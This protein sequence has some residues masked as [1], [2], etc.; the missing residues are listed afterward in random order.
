MKKKF[1]SVICLITLVF[2]MLFSAGCGTS[3]ADK[4]EK[5]NNNLLVLLLL[6]AS[7]RSSATSSSSGSSR[8]TCYFAGTSGGCTSSIPYTC[9]A[10]SYCSSSSTCS[11]LSCSLTPTAAEQAFTNALDKVKNDSGL[12]KSL[13]LAVKDIG[14]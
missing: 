10:S 9:T 6:L 13:E 14:K 7:S 12:L 3:K 1:I 4:E 8:T 11:N 2:G 5:D